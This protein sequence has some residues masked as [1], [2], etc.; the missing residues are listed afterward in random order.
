MKARMQAKLV[1][2]Q[3]IHYFMY[4]IPET[5]NKDHRSIEDTFVTVIQMK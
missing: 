2:Q 3:E 5:L 4:L 1:L